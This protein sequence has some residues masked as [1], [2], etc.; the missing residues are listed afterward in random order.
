MK[1]F[2]L[3]LPPYMPSVVVLL[4]LFY[5]TLVPQPLPEMDVPILNFDKIVHIIM[6][7]G[8]YLTFAYDYTR[9]ERQHR[10]PFPVILFLL[11]V[12]ILLGGLIELAQ[13]T[14]FIH[15]GCDFWDFVAD[16]IGALL[17]SLV[18]RR[19]VGYLLG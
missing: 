11:V 2:L 17:G 9:R 15:R 12:T 19:V 1:K 14:E 13:G 8:V 7:M 16:S 4:V 6:M 18:A 5:F 3:G 10:L